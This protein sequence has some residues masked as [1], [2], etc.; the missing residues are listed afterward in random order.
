[1]AEGHPFTAVV[2][3]GRMPGLGG[4]EVARRLRLAESGRGSV[5]CRIIILSGD[6]AAGK[7]PGFGQGKSGVDAVLA[8]PVT[9]AGLAH[10]LLPAAGQ[11]VAGAA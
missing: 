5:P 10:A 1:M 7:R 4:W 11:A 3:D 9:F 2:L 6:A 8:K